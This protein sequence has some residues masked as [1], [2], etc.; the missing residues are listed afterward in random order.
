MEEKSKPLIILVTCMSLRPK[1]LTII[2]K[3]IVL[4]N[5]PSRDN[6]I[7]AYM[8]NKSSHGFAD[9]SPGDLP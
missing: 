7:N 1:L 4:D 6:I 9:W 3:P 5:K 8:P 2:N